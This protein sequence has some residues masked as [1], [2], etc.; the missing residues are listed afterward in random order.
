MQPPVNS[1]VLS[2]TVTVKLISFSIH[3]LLLLFTL[4]S[5]VTSKKVHLLNINDR[6]AVSVV[7]IVIGGV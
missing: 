2:P 3:Q 4:W 1:P 7:A 6:F 5:M